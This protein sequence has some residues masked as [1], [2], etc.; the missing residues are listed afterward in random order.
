MLTGVDAS[1]QSNYDRNL[2]VPVSLCRSLKTFSTTMLKIRC[3]TYNRRLNPGTFAS[4]SV[5]W[6]AK[7]I[8]A[9]VLVGERA[10]TL[11]NRLK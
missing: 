4:Y 9:R 6:Q 2:K 8:N 5:V 7:R 10:F 3:P 11:Y 1:T